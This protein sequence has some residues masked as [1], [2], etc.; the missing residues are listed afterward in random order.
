MAKLFVLKD[1]VMTYIFTIVVRV[2]TNRLQRYKTMG[3]HPNESAEN[4]RGV[5]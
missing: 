2:S 3:K 4:F 5:C 1:V